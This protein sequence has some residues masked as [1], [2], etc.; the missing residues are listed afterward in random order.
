M[1]F[2]ATGRLPD[3]R[4]RLGLAAILLILAGIL[5]LVPTRASAGDL[6]AW[7]IVGYSA[8]ARHFAFS[9]YGRQDGSG[10]PY[11][12]LYLIDLE[13]DRYVGG[14][15]FRALIKDESAS[16]GHA[17]AQVHA[18]AENALSSF[19]IAQPGRI[20]AADPPTE[21]DADR[22]RIVFNPAPTVT[23][24]S[25]MRTLALTT[26]PL[27]DKPICAQMGQTL[28]FRAHA[29]RCRGLSRQDHPR[30]PQL[31]PRLPDCRHRHAG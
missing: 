5:A 4:V 20:A 18:Q 9:E 19:A 22:R 26:L 12:A 14:A 6:A 28:R 29:R 30:E 13:A 25:A 10:F 2:Q 27:P 3:S 11:A 15:P 31:P 21:Q 16:V 17:L 8:D 23:P 7:Q 24:I 1:A